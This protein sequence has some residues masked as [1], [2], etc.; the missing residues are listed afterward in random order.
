M[1]KWKINLGSETNN[2]GELKALFALLKVVEGR[3]ILHLLIFGDS[4][5]VIDWMRGEIHV[6]NLGLTYIVAQQDVIAT[7]F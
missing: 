6:M 1:I 4:I 3:G 2:L 7:R 5:L